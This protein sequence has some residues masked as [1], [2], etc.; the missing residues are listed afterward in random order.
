RHEARANYYIPT[1]SDKW[2]LRFS[3]RSGHIFGLDQDVRI[4]HRFFIGG[5][6][7][8]GFRNDGIGPHDRKT[9]DALGGNTYYS[10]S[11]ELSFPLG[12]PEELGF[13]GAV[14]ADAGSLFNIDASGPDIE[15]SKELRASLGAG[16][17]WAS[18]FG[19]VRIDFAKAVLK[20]KFDDAQLVRFSFGTRF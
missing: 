4:N 6:D 9:R 2:I 3:A 8:R 10:G 5:D 20:N 1:I 13:S 14:F 12:L 19:P 16:V 15:D 18:P 17:G 11:T 7:L